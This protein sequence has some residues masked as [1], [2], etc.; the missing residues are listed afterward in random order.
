M[1]PPPRGRRRLRLG[2][3]AFWRARRLPGARGRCRLRLRHGPSARQLGGQRTVLATRN[4]GF[5]MPPTRRFLVWGFRTLVVLVLLSLLVLGVR[6]IVRNELVR[7]GG[8]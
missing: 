4:K 6:D 3:G 8:T 7:P 5:R 1:G 2:R